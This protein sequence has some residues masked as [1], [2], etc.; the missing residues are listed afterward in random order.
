MGYTL[1]QSDTEGIQE[2]L[3]VVCASTSD[4]EAI[5]SAL[6]SLKALIGACIINTPLPSY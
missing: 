1:D 3:D 4:E 5:S 6:M 2:L